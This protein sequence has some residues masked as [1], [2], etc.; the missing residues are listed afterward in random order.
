MEHREVR[1]L[2]DGVQFVSGVAESEEGVSA[3]KDGDPN[4]TLCSGAGLVSTANWFITFL[5]PWC[6]LEV[7]G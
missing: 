3:A 6:C 4:L 2:A 1:K 7:L 5:S